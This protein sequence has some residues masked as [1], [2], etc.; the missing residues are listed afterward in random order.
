M[1]IK[2]FIKEMF[3]GSNLNASH[4]QKGGML[5]VSIVWILIF[6]VPLIIF[7]H[8]LLET[9]N[10]RTKV[11]WGPM[12]FIWDALSDTPA[13]LPTCTSL[14]SPSPCVNQLCTDSNTPY[15]GCTVPT[16]TGINIPYDGCVKANCTSATNV[17]YPGCTISVCSTPTPLSGYVAPYR[18][19]YCPTEADLNTIDGCT[20][21]PC[22]TAPNVPYDGCTQQECITS[23]S[24][25][26]TGC[27]VADCST[28]PTDPYEGCTPTDCSTSPSDPY[29]GCN[30]AT[31]AEGP[32]VAALTW[33]SDGTLEAPAN[34]QAYGGCYCHNELQYDI[35]RMPS[36]ATDEATT[37]T[38]CVVEGCTPHGS[39][40]ELTLP[41]PM[42]QNSLNEAE[43]LD[44]ANYLSATSRLCGS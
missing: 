41:E 22:T 15:A 7:I 36:T 40:S 10:S 11:C 18:G 12:E 1:T 20:P 37:D 39:G 38:L 4:I 21:K 16:C 27:T 31:C 44:A 6:M 5:G 13:T 32:S 29:L 28:S 25:P 43:R 35:G 26:Y 2:G 14:N 42:D 34:L 17:P 9:D 19:C 33:A 3:G 30:I 8:L 24:D 23:T